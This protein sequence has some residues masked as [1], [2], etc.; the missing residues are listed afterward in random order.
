LP[1][2]FDIP[3]RLVYS[4]HIYDHSPVEWKITNQFT[5]DWFMN[6]S[7]A[8]MRQ[9]GKKY[10]APVW[11]GEFGTDHDNKFWK[12]IIRYLERNNNIHWSYWA[13]NGYKGTPEVD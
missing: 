7:V 6:K 9:E 10:T 2:E 1:I 12:L 5:F 4:F 8:F 3:N 13:Y 11:I